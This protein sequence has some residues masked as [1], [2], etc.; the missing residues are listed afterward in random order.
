M[1][2]ASTGSRVVVVS[3]VAGLVWLFVK[4]NPSSRLGWPLTVVAFTALIAFFLILLT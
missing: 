1:T 3:L 4:R 2:H